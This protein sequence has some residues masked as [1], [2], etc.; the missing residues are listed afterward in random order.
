[1]RGGGAPGRGDVEQGD[2]RDTGDFGSVPSHQGRPAPPS[3]SDEPSR[4]GS[5]AG[6]GRMRP[7]RPATEETVPADEAS[8]NA[9]DTEDDSGATAEDD[10]TG[11]DPG[12]EPLGADAVPSGQPSDPLPPAESGEPGRAAVPAGQAVEPV[13]RILPLGSGL[14]LVGLGLGCAFVGLRLRR[15]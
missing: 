14:V 1:G 10:D 12:E 5:R 2:G 13:L 8:E 6:E 15:G 7:G 11:T 4:A 3:P 9:E